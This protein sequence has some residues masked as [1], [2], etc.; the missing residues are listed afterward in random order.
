VSNDPND[1]Y[2]GYG[3]G[4]PY[5]QP[6]G[7][8]YGGPPP[9]GPP[10]GDPYGRPPPGYPGGPRDPYGPSADPQAVRGRVTPPAIF[11]IVVGALNLLGSF[12]CFGLVY[13]LISLGPDGVK[14]EVENNPALKNN[15]AFQQEFQKDPK[16]AFNQAVTE[17]EVLGGLSFVAA[18]ITLIGA[19]RMLALKTWWLALIGAILAAVPCVS[20]TG[21]CL[22]GEAAGIWSLVVLLN[23]QV[24]SAF[25]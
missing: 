14:R 12:G 2:G 21:C 20:P 15:P 24:R 17:Y 4:D 25:R 6:P 22:L 10:P 13:Q 3:A 23:G 5:G 16:G 19:F 11:L 8:G 7:G 9:G 18:I 1:P